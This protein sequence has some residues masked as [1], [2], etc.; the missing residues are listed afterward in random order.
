MDVWVPWNTQLYLWDK[1]TNVFVK[2]NS[3]VL[4]LQPSKALMTQFAFLLLSIVSQ[5]LMY[6]I[7]NVNFVQ[8]IFF[9]AETFIFLSSLSQV[10]LY[11]LQRIPSWELLQPCYFQLLYF[12][13]QQL[14]TKK[15]FSIFFFLDNIVVCTMIKSLHQSITRLNSALVILSKSL[16][17]VLKKLN[18]FFKKKIH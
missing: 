18:Q 7:S 12:D 13:N 17:S 3:L 1:S 6:L 2:N 15:K 8:S 14:V 16:S 11:S 10:I 5:H 4:N 9:F